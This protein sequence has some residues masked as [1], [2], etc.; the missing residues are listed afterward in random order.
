VIA[1]TLVVGLVLFTAVVLQTSLFPSLTLAGYRPDLL[2]LLTVAIALKDGPMSGCRVG[3]TA[4]VL[5]DALV[6]QTPIGVAALVFT[7]FG[8]VVGFARPY[9]AP[10]SVSAPVLIAF[11]T[12]VLGT[13]AYG[14]LALLLG[15][16]RVTLTLLGQAAL[17]V[18]LYNTLLAPLVLG[19]ATRL[20]E[21]L[22]LQ[23]TN[24]GELA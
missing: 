18:G 16:D 4:G 17:S 8:F 12:G 13:A 20:S 6:A 1:R 9:L 15:D 7:V 5:T 21:R 24:V 14:V 3:F 10:D 19:F 2:L 11:A 23:G 22:P